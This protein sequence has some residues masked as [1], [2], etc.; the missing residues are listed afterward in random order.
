[1]HKVGG[2]GLSGEIALRTFSQAHIE[3]V[4]VD[5]GTHLSHQAHAFGIV[6]THIAEQ[7][8]NIGFHKHGRVRAVVGAESQASAHREAAILPVGGFHQVA[9]S[10]AIAEIDAQV[11]GLRHYVV[12]VAV[13]GNAG[14]VVQCPILAVS[15]EALFVVDFPVDLARGTESDAAIV[16]AHYG[17]LR[18]VRSGKVDVKVFYGDIG[19]AH[20]AHG[21]HATF[22][23]QS[24]AC[25][26]ES[27][28]FPTLN[29]NAGG[30]MHHLV[31]IGDIIDS[32]GGIVG[33]EAI[34][35]FLE[36]HGYLRAIGIL[37]DALQC[38]I[39]G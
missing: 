17:Y 26:V 10:G 33:R 31:V 9:L 24:A 36:A 11:A 2:I 32:V 8:A 4:E 14:V 35:A 38:S 3:A 19:A 22:A 21:Q 27:E 15:S 13:E 7:G 28:T 6:N 5:I 23:E 39:D 30:V 20:N 34:G 1:M 16:V 25:A 29:G 12:S 37:F 18:N